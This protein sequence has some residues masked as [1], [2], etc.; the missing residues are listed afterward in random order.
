MDSISPSGSKTVDYRLDC[1]V[2]LKGLV[3]QAVYGFIIGNS[4][5]YD[6]I[7]S[8]RNSMSLKLHVEMGNGFPFNVS[9]PAE[10]NSTLNSRFITRMKTSFARLR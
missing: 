7:F 3:W 1:F 6:F 9:T 5:I 8:L 2:M 4:I 10:Q